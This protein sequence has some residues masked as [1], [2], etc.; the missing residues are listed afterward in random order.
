MKYIITTILFFSTTFS[1]AQEL[2]L[3]G[4]EYF[5]YPKSQINDALKSNDV[6]FQEFGAFINI[7]LQ[8]KN[9]KTVLINGFR[10]ASVRATTHNASLFSSNEKNLQKIAYSLNFVHKWNEKW[11]IIAGVSPTL[12]S[13]FKEKISSDD[14]IFQGNFLVSKKVS[15]QF[16][17]GG[18]LIYTTQLGKPRL[19]PALQVQYQTDKHQLTA[20]LPSFL[21]YH[22]KVGKN[23]KLRIGFRTAL[24]GGN[25]NVSAQGFPGTVSSPINKVIYSRANLGP[26][27]NYQLTKIIQ[28]EAFGGIS[29]ARKYRLE[30]S[31]QADYKYDSKTSAFFNIGFAITPQKK[32]VD[33]SPAGN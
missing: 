15:M 1:K 20:L 27:I 7:P 25:F 18:G 16:T 10:Y 3:A 22:Y 23:E 6:S 30:D 11:L 9:K 13:D 29:G 32:K 24:N 33:T 28:F 14:L 2:K 5:N 4:I 17:I 21:S 8:L 31:D 12:A 19:L 26:V